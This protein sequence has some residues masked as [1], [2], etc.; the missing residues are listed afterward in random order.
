M[1][2]DGDVI[3]I[4]D[5]VKTASEAFDNYTAM[6]Q[7]DDDTLMKM[8]EQTISADKGNDIK[9]TNTSEK[10]L[11]ILLKGNIDEKAIFNQS[12]F[13]DAEVG[14]RTYIDFINALNAT[15]DGEKVL[16]ESMSNKYLG[17][18]ISKYFS[19]S[20]KTDQVLNI[21]A[22]SNKIPMLGMDITR[23]SVLEI[24]E[25]VRR[26][27]IKEVM[28]NT[29]KGSSTNSMYK[30][31]EDLDVSDNQKQ[32]LYSLNSWA[33]LQNDILIN[34]NTVIS[35]AVS[36]VSNLEQHKEDDKT[37]MRNIKGNLKRII[38]D[39]YNIGSKPNYGNL[40]EQYSSDYNEYM[41]IK[42]SKLSDLLSDM[43]AD[44]L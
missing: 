10:L 43:N 21:N 20:D 31:I 16:G 14:R 13:I 26:E 39:D 30:F 7:I 4:A 28:M 3:K 17:D 9:L 37:L 23:M 33:H 18:M 38:D 15:Q 2:T 12:E 32:A 22:K 35:E 29:S 42:K 11:R 34:D 36:I 1:M 6:N 8:L 25:V 40:S 5:R 41:A 27:M 44:T 24:D 19:N